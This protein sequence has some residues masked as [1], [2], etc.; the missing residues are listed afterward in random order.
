MD[1]RLQ[2]FTNTRALVVGDL[3]L[4]RYWHG[5]T[6]R[7]SPEAPVPI[8]HVGNV[9]ER[10]GG[11]ANVAANICALGGQATLIGV[12]GADEDGE[13]LAEICQGFG[14][15]TRF[16]RASGTP[17]TVKLRVVSQHQ[18]LVRA[19]FESPVNDDIAMAV[20]DIV[21]DEIRAAD[22]VVI[23]DYAK[24]ALRF[25]EQ[26]IDVARDAGVPVVVDPKGG[27]FGR[28]RGASLITP[29]RKE[30]EA[31]CGSFQSDEMLERLGTK[32]LAE[33]DFEAVLV[34]RGAEGMTLISQGGPA[35]KVTANSKDVFDVT[36]AGDTVSAA[37]SLSMPNIS[38]WQDRVEIANAAAG[39]VVER[40]G[41]ATVD[42]DALSEALAVNIE[43]TADPI[44]S[45]ESAIELC[46]QA[47]ARNERVVFTNGC[48]DLLHPGH[49]EY[50]AEA[51][52]LGDR[53]IVAVNDD[54]SVRS[55]KGNDRPIN[56]LASR[57]RVL[58]SLRSVDWV[59]YFSETTPLKLI[60][61]ILPDVLAKGGDYAVEDVVGGDV[62][63]SNGGNVV[64][65]EFRD[66]HSTSA[67][68]QRINSEGKTG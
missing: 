20:C 21:R 51:R 42:L 31:V 54:E 30:F 26:I 56:P 64:I 5:E 9:E 63:S 33:H 29:N 45:P 34:T 67:V 22:I 3:I 59:T 28:Y 55:L 38:R 44:V 66:G 49:V 25:V 15:K 46:H 53:L 39:V 52:S 32:L 35:I 14:I 16:E 47:Q 23:S 58:S 68:V 40:F 17:T 48:F 62:V 50:L 43:R 12:V 6:S 2:A 61:A 10:A 27:D 24:G 60:E 11:A 65:I 1:A 37:I 57:M 8:V 13:K 4:D 19:D 41:A 7:I 36:G 18:Q